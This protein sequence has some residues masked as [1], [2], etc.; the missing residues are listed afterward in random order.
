MAWHGG[1]QSGCVFRT[2]L[3]GMQQF[4]ESRSF[5]GTVVQA[6]LRCYPMPVA[7]PLWGEVVIPVCMLDVTATA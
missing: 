2:H 5:P 1:V 6:S 7:Q 3:S 4:L